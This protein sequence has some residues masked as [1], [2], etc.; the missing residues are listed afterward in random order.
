MHFMVLMYNICIYI[1]VYIY[2]YIY[3]YVYSFIYYMDVE[4]HLFHFLQNDMYITCEYVTQRQKSI[5]IS[6]YHC[7]LTSVATM[8]NVPIPLL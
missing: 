6:S 3:I 2:I 5:M 8:R 7:I 4:Y 1:Y